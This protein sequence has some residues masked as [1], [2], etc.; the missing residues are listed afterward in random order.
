MMTHRAAL[1]VPHVSSDNALRD[2]ASADVVWSRQSTNYWL[3][4][5]S[6]GIIDG[7]QS[8]NMLLLNV[9]ASELRASPCQRTD[10]YKTS[11]VASP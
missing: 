11:P 2:T 10:E 7:Q 6:V 1:G 8:R 5:R 4:R 3:V 9:S